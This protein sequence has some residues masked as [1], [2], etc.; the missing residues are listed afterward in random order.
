MRL[1][2]LA[3]GAMFPSKFERK[4]EHELDSHPG[5]RPSFKIPIQEIIFISP[6]FSMKNHRA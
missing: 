2:A 3:I 4:I 6:F 5:I 1:L